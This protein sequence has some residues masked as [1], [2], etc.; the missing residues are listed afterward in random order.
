MSKVKFTSD[1]MQRIAD[2]WEIFFKGEL[3]KPMIYFGSVYSHFDD[4]LF[5]KS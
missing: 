4:P 1:E 5:R 2:E 3:D